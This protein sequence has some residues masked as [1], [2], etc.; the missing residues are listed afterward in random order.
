MQWN[1]GDNRTWNELHY[2]ALFFLAHFYSKS[3][4]F[5]FSSF[6]SVRSFDSLRWL[7]AFCCCSQLTAADSTSRKKIDLEQCILIN[8]I[9]NFATKIFTLVSLNNIFCL[10]STHSLCSIRSFVGYHLLDNRNYVCNWILKATRAR[11]DMRT[12]TCWRNGKRCLNRTH[13]P[14][15]IGACVRNCFF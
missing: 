11:A 9:V 6:C 3:L 1:Y 7:N 5:F 13:L 15:T 10:L 14:N 4:P 12:M 2:C 8:F